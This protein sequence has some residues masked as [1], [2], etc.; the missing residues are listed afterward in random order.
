MSADEILIA[1]KLNAVRLLPATWSKRFIIAMY[2]TSIDK[3]E[4]E[5]S[6]SQKEWLYRNLYKYRK[7]VPVTY[8]K[9]KDH[10]HCKPLKK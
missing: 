4:T 8:Q 9:F 5:L 6:E 2:F 10:P 3:P 1:Q 7:Q